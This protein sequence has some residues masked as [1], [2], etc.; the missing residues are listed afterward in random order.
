MDDLKAILTSNKISAIIIPKVE[1]AKDIHF[2]CELIEKF[3][4][5]KQK[6]S[7][8]LL[9]CIESPKSLMNIKEI[10]QADSKI[11]ALVVKSV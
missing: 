7:I 9:A 8:K 11:D 3:A 10:C 1:S 4:P 2:T 6:S 5:Q